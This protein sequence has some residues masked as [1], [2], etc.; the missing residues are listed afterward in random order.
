[1]MIFKKTKAFCGNV[2]LA[3]A[4]AIVI[5]LLLIAIVFDRASY[6]KTKSIL[7]GKQ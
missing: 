2:G 6:Q 3:L 4:F 7:N 5:A 1:M